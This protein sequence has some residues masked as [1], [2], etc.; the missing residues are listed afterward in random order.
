M[1]SCC[2]NVYA[3]T[4]FQGDGDLSKA[5]QS[6]RERSVNMKNKYGT[7][8]EKNNEVEKNKNLSD[9]KDCWFG[10]NQQL[11]AHTIKRIRRR[12]AGAGASCSE[13]L[14]EHHRERPKPITAKDLQQCIRCV[15]FV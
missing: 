9:I 2:L 11:G 5:I 8:Q 6:E 3:Y 15:D 4:W 13:G 7:I 14:G 12:T 10:K 1:C